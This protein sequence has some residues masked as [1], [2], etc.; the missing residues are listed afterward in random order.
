MGAIQS[1]E[2][3]QKVK[4]DDSVK[5]PACCI[6]ERKSKNQIA[7]MIGSALVRQNLHF[8]IVGIPR[9]TPRSK[10]SYRMAAFRQNACKVNTV[11]LE[12]AR[13]E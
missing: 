11:A 8:E 9:L 1:V 3:I 7:L 12:A 13:S 4:P 10:N 5:A 2:A 6:H